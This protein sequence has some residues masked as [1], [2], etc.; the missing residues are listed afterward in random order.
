MINVNFSNDPDYRYKM[1]APQLQNIGGGNGKRFLFQNIALVSQKI[2]RNPE[3]LQKYL[4]TEFGAFG[5]LQQDGSLS[6]TGWQDAQSVLDKIKQFIFSYVLCKH[7]GN[8]ETIQII[9]PN[10]IIFKCKA[11]GKDSTI[12]A[13]Q[14]HQIIMWQCKQIKKTVISARVKIAPRAIRSKI[15]AIINSDIENKIN[16]LEREIQNFIEKGA[17]LEEEV[18]VLIVSAFNAKSV[19]EETDFELFSKVCKKLNFTI[20]QQLQILYSMECVFKQFLS[21]FAANSYM[22]SGIFQKFQ[23]LKIIDSQCFLQFKEAE[24]QQFVPEEF[25]GE[26]LANLKPFYDWF[27][28]GDVEVQEEIV[29]IEEVEE[30][31]E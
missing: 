2:F 31:T 15:E 9:E 10:R 22:L 30:E 12:E 27:E 13:C 4:Q 23:V 3:I 19:I 14:Q 5:C 1:P 6:L 11:C 20:Q 28:S 16:V 24:H 18:V 17:V 7:C 26:I 8:P 29:E 25:H 21:V